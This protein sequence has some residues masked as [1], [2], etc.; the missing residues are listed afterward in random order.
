MARGTPRLH[1][2][3][4]MSSDGRES[5]REGRRQTRI[6]LVGCGRIARLSHLEVL[7]R[8]PDA[9][10]V[11]FADIDRESLAMARERAPRARA[12]EDYREL[13]SVVGP[14]AVLVALP[15]N[16][17]RDAAI[18]AFGA[19]A[20]LYL[21]KPIAGTL[22]EAKEIYDSWKQTSLVGR[23]GF[24]ARFNRLYVRLRDAVAGGEIGRPVAARSAFTALFP[25][26]AT[27]RTKPSTGGGALL[28]LASHHVDLMRF[29]FG[30]G[31]RSI[32][33]TTWSNRGDDE[34]AMLEIEL[35]N[36]VHVQTLV[37]YGTIEEDSFEIFGTEGKLRVNRYDSLI[38]EKI[39]PRAAGGLASAV[40]RLR[41]EVGALG[42][43]LEKRKS[44]GQE[45]SFTAS[46]GQFL[47]AVRGG[48]QS[49]PDLGDGLRAV[50]VI[51]AAK[52][53]AVDRSVVEI[54][55]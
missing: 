1:L 25:A 3:I 26:E 31:A 36:G 16:L 18:A 48:S 11:A 5:A 12:F 40:G 41:S 13:L 15:T 49:S 21:E 37:A 30:S 42:Y 44:P 46:I 39:A 33:A 34:S 47:G 19:G 8:H 17:H 22:R 20:H 52:R 35:G 23:I 38:V 6:A 14:E 51:D 50:E 7:A 9:E 53:S 24:N 4:A 2:Y 27:W 54:A 45:P 10:L 32:R 43:G 55:E 29:V 28:E